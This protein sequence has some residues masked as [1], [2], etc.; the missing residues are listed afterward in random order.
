[1]QSYLKRLILP[2]TLFV[3]TLFTI[4]GCHNFF[5]NFMVIAPSSTASAANLATTSLTFSGPLTVALQQ[6]L[7]DHSLEKDL[8]SD[9]ANTRKIQIQFVAF[10]TVNEA[11]ELLRDEKVDLVFP[12]TPLLKTEFHGHYT[13]VY[14]DLRLSVV[15]GG[16]LIS[17]KK[18]YFP[19]NYFYATKSKN[20]NL[21]FEVSAKNLKSN[22]AKIYVGESEVFGRIRFD[23]TFNDPASEDGAIT[24]KL[25]FLSSG[26]CLDLPI[27][28]DLIAYLSAQQG[29]VDH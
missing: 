8:I 12:R 13:M 21:T 9:F 20:F 17:A 14:D 16:A 4:D 29:I 22:K 26:K 2:V 15:C 11:L 24:V 25:L 5:N 6:D 7:M 3:S 23:K 19:E 27:V 1:M 28:I 10:E 18:L